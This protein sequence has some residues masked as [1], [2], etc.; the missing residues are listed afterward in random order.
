APEDEALYLLLHAA[1]HLFLDPLWLYDL[2]LFLR[3][4][5]D[6]D[7]ARIARRARALRVV[8]ALLMAVEMLE[9][10]LGVSV[11]GCSRIERRHTWLA[12]LS[13]LTMAVT[14]RQPPGS[15]RETAGRMLF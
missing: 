8:S 7:W 4:Y 13:R 14:A 15:R 11:P 6:L 2:K 1:R 5:P 12:A 9:R 10:R 3:I